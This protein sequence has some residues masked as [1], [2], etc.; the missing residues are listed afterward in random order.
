MQKALAATYHTVD[1]DNL[2]ETI[3]SG[4]TVFAVDIEE[5]TPYVG[6]IIPQNAFRFNEEQTILEVFVGKNVD[7]TK[8]KD[9]II[10]REIHFPDDQNRRNELL[11]ECIERFICRNYD[12]CYIAGHNEIREY[13]YP[14]VLIP[15]IVIEETRKWLYDSPEH[16]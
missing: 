13:Q 9:L 11:R 16:V 3:L 6:R 15:R 7:W 8:Q 5:R 14:P 12:M 4:A 2:M 1:A 10:N